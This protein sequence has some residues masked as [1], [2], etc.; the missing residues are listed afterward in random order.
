MISP[1]IAIFAAVAG[2]AV[3]FF[4]MFLATALNPGARNL[5]RRTAAMQQR[6]RPGNA[7]GAAT[8]KRAFDPGQFVA[9]EALARRWLPNTRQL[10]QRLARTGR[11]I[12]LGAYAATVS[13]TA[14]FVF[15]FLKF[16][17]GMSLGVAL[18]A[19]IAAGIGIPHTAIGIM[20][21]RRIGKFTALL[22]DA[23]E[24]LVRGLRSGLPISK[25]IHTVG[26]EIAD[27]VGLEFRHV[28]DAVRFGKTLEDA[29]WETAERLDTQEFKFFVISLAVQKET[30]GNL[31]ETLENLADILRDRK[32]MKLKIKA[33]SSEA[34]ASA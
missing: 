8:L 11:R 31:A 9:L 6:Y 30:G 3:L 20:G 15:V 12:T 34:R 28:A 4:G 16:L 21:G 25:C 24:L 2:L 26:N 22:P 32:Q 29:L 17:L 1:N 7:A 23:I 13:A 33:M 5:R 19:A 27:P 14:I 10:N 18:P